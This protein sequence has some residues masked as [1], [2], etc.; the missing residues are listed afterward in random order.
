MKRTF[1]LFLG[2]GLV[3]IATIAMVLSDGA[4]RRVADARAQVSRWAEQLH[5]QTTD[6][7]VYIRHPA[8]QL[9]ENDPWGTPLNVTYAQGG[10]AETLTVRS[11]GPDGVFFTQDDILAQRS[12]VNLKGIGRG[13]KDNIEEFAQDGARGLTR[14]VADGIRESVQEALAEKK[15]ERRKKQ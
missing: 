4:S 1:I 12:V 2:V 6:A 11:A 15:S 13:A 5:G 9:P 10:F 8:N 7:G 14:G 3:C